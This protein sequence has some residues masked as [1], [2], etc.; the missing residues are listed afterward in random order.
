[1]KPTELE[2][3]AGA[4]MLLATMVESLGFCRIGLITFGFPS[5]I[6]LEIYTAQQG[7]RLVPD[8]KCSSGF[9]MAKEKGWIETLV[10]VPSKDAMSIKEGMFPYAAEFVNQFKNPTPKGIDVYFVTAAGWNEL[11]RSGYKHSIIT[12]E[13]I[14]TLMIEAT[15]KFKNTLPSNKFCFGFGIFGPFIDGTEFGGRELSLALAYLHEHKL[16]N[17]RGVQYSTR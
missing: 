11:Q 15:A 7:C 17:R 13:N 1:M 10:A 8:Q 2:L 14:D 12:S 5:Q 6:K 3:I 4:H 9:D 16:L